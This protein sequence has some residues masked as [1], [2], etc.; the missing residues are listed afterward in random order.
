MVYR[1]L[2]ASYFLNVAVIDDVEVLGDLVELSHGLKRSF[3]G[4]L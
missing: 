2:L 4:F 3:V 1:L